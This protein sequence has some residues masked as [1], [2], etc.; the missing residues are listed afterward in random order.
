VS[1]RGEIRPNIERVIAEVMVKDKAKLVSEDG[2]ELHNISGLSENDFSRERNNNVAEDH[3]VD[4]I[5]SDVDSHSTSNSIELLRTSC[6]IGK[7][8]S[9]ALVEI[10]SEIPWPCWQIEVLHRNISKKC[11]NKS[12]GRDGQSMRNRGGSSSYINSD[13]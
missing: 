11:E 3:N 10:L 13:S 2:N 5:S 6:E 8:K 9:V 4:S 7:H 12:S 1:R